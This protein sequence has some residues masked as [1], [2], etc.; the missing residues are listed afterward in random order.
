FKAL[1]YFNSPRVLLQQGGIFVRSPDRGI[2][3]PR[4][5]SLSGNRTQRTPGKPP[6]ISLKKPGTQNKNRRNL[7]QHMNNYQTIIS[8]RQRKLRTSRTNTRNPNPKNK[9]IQTGF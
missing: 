4:Y 3:L 2:R 7:Q 8:W 6:F 1:L 9:T 5:L